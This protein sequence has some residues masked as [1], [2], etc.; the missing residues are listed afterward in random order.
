MLVFFEIFKKRNRNESSEEEKNESK[1]S[2]N[3]PKSEL[4]MSEEDRI[5]RTNTKFSS[6]NFSNPT[7]EKKTSLNNGDTKIIK[8][9]H[10]FMK[11]E[12]NMNGSSRNTNFTPNTSRYCSSNNQIRVFPQQAC[13]LQNFQNT[14]VFDTRAGN[15]YGNAIPTTNLPYIQYNCQNINGNRV[16]LG[17]NFNNNP[18]FYNNSNNIIIVPYQSQFVQTN[19]YLFGT[20]KWEREAQARETRIFYFF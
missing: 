16:E 11:Q 9:E 12:E 8:E 14:L 19:Q 17:H 20:W 15:F 18:V 6:E 10:I 4:F 3:A 7:H 13:P 5:T 1:I 2:A